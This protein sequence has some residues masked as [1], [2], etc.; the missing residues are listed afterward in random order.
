[1]LVAAS[2]SVS[3]KGTTKQRLGTDKTEPNVLNAPAGTRRSDTIE[4]ASAKCLSVHFA[5]FQLPPGD[6]VIARSVNGQASF[7]FEGLGRGDH[8]LDGGFYSPMRIDGVVRL[9]GNAD[10]ALGYRIDYISRS[11]NSASPSSICGSEDQSKNPQ[12]FENDIELPSA[13]T[14]SRAVARLYSQ[15]YGSDADSTEYEFMVEL[16]CKSKP[17]RGKLS[18]RGV[19]VATTATLVAMSAPELLDCAL[20]KLHTMVELSQFGNLTLRV[21]RPK[22]NES[23]HVPQYPRGEPK[24]LATVRQDGGHTQ[25]APLVSTRDNAVIGMHNCGAC[26]RE[27]DELVAHPIATAIEWSVDARLRGSL[28][29]ASITV[30]NINIHDCIF[31]TDA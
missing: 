28:G 7:E 31:I 26:A 17:P 19:R 10:G 2:L 12:C 30:A 8:G 3:A 16:P 20:V 11:I 9:N 25:I 29:A 15:N 18:T 5:H 27:Y 21:A 4:A 13:Y 14:K 23:V 6:K 1:M 22:V 24:R